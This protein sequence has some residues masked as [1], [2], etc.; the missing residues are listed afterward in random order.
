ML[1]LMR[2]AK[3]IPEKTGQI[4]NFGSVFPV[5]LKCS[6]VLTLCACEIKFDRFQKDAVA[7]FLRDSVFSFARSLTARLFPTGTTF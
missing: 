1:F 7:D 2:N 3:P 4:L 6:T 5:F